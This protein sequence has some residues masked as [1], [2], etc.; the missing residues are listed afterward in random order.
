[1]GTPPVRAGASLALTGRYAS[2]ARQSARGLEEWANSCG[3]TLRI[4]DSGGDEATT[5]RQT[6][7]LADICDVVFGPYGSGPMRAVATA[8][9][10]R[11]DVIWNH[12]GAAATG[13]GAR[14]IDVLAPARRYWADLP[15]ALTRWGL[16]L[17]S[18]AVLQAKSPFGREVAAGAIAALADAGH[19]PSAVITF[20]ENQAPHAV[21][22]ALDSGATVIVTGARYEEDV[23]V[24]RAAVYHPHLALGMVA[25]GVDDAREAFGDALLGW[26]GPC[27][28]IDTPR[29]PV[30]P[31]LDAFTAY[32]AVQAFAAGCLAEQAIAAAGTCEPDVV[33]NAAR[34]LVTRTFFGDFAVDEQG[35]QTAH[36]PVIV[37]WGSGDGGPHRHPA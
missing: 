14:I 21:A 28:W 37:R 33:W 13:T 18:V 32:P 15:A 20:T 16:P 10:D 34:A 6:R 36:R 11:S 25:C 3:A 30:P 19:S 8:F 26:F 23:A 7:A 12:G 17:H 24:G 27:Q 2:F 5:V 22:R 31:Q 9:A 29:T 1:M 35:R 4:D